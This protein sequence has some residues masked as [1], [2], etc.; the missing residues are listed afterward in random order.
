M[1]KF[2]KAII[3]MLAVIILAGAVLTVGYFK[4]F[5][6]EDRLTEQQIAFLRDK[7][8]IYGLK[9]PPTVDMAPPSL[10]SG[11]RVADTFVY[12]EILEELPTYEKYIPFG[13]PAFD[14][15]TEGKGLSNTETFYEHSVL[16]IS[17]S[18]GLYE[19]GDVITI[20]A[21]IIFK[22]HNP[23]LKSGMKFVIPVSKD[24][25]KEGRTQFSVSGMYHVTDDGYVIS[26]FDEATSKQKLSGIKVESFFK[27]VR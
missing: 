15:K 19:K 5:Q 8:P 4:P 20:A 10:E 14:G 11:I 1:K 27:K 23:E 24:D 3:C 25:D 16:V 2:N 9:T 18:E 13:I 21:N 26:A 22:E 6:P 7:Y 17:D 12:G